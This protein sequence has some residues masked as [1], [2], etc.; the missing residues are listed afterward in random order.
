MLFMV[1]IDQHFNVVI[2]TISFQIFLFIFSKLNIITSEKS[3]KFILLGLMIPYLF[4]GFCSNLHLWG[5]D[6]QEKYSLN[7]PQQSN[8]HFNP[9]DKT[10][11]LSSNQ[12]LS[13]SSD[14]QQC[15]VS[16]LEETVLNDKL[17]SYFIFSNL[18]IIFLSL[19]FVVG[20]FVV[21]NNNIKS[22]YMLPPSFAYLN[23]L[24]LQKILL[25]I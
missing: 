3:L 23:S 4:L 18:Q 1:I 21:L 16:N 20:A 7:F 5:G 11:F 19:S 22:F 24:I 17:P 12:P 2:N 8:V 25:R 10:H 15:C 13:N 14:F 9:S 6:E